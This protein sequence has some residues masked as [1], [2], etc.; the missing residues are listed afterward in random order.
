MK[1]RIGIAD[2]NKVVEIDVADVDDFKKEIERS[3]GEGGL[4]WFTD[5]RGRTVGVPARSM[6]FVEIDAES[7]SQAVGFAPAV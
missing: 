2:T 6:A 4:A 1:V 7:G 3:L 5:T